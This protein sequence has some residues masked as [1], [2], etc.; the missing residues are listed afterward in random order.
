M[1]KFKKA[2]ATL[3][4]TSA[5]LLSSSAFAEATSGAVVKAAA[6]GTVA[7]ISEAVSLQEKGASAE[8]V[9]KV[10]SEVRQLQKEFRF[11]GTE[12]ARQLAGNQLKI[13]TAEVKSGDPAAL[14]S[15]K[16]TQAMYQDML[17]VYNK[18]H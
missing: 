17:V 1:E 16:K 13:A 10:L 11:E 9:G 3:V 6:E 5:M 14:E 18:A 2:L 15:L 8:E 7:K 4:M 12:R